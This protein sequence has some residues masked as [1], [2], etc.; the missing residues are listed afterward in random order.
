MCI[1]WLHLGYIHYHNCELPLVSERGIGESCVEPAQCQAVNP[2]STCNLPSG[3]CSCQEGY[4]W[5]S[6]TC[7]EG[8][9]WK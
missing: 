1:C 6:T 2:D 8:K 3:K 7:I 5:N 9:Y 4:L